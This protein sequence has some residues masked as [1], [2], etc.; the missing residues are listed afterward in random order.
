MRMFLDDTFP[1]N[2]ITNKPSTLSST[3]FV[4]RYDRITKMSRRIHH[5]T[6]V[7]VNILTCTTLMA[8]TTIQA[9][10]GRRQYVIPLHRS[11]C[12]R[13]FVLI[14][15]SSTRYE[16]ARSKATLNLLLCS[17]RPGSTCFYH[18][19]SCRHT[20]ESRSSSLV[21]LYLTA[22]PAA[23]RASSETTLALLG[24]VAL[25]LP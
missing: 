7:R 20:T 14:D 21:L 22:P 4:L 6:E 8:G 16:D 23:T 18:F 11:A 25:P 15:C 17:L 9:Q 1:K 3:C 10:K 19:E 12:L 24:R 13:L 5:Y 2:P